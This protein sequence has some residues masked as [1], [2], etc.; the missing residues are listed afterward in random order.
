[1]RSLQQLS[2][3]PNFSLSVKILGKPLKVW[4]LRFKSPTACINEML[5]DGHG[6]IIVLFGSQTVRVS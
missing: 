3:I 4:I 1:V 2:R 5:E 6:Q